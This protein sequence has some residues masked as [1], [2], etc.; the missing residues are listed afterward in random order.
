MGLYLAHILASFGLSDPR[1]GLV[2]LL[3]DHAQPAQDSVAFV[4]YLNRLNADRH[5]GSKE[6]QRVLE[7]HASSAAYCTHA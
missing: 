3:A 1:A 4:L 7:N 2:Y 5:A 6:N